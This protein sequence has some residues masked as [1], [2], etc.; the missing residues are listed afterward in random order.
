MRNA[1]SGLPRTCTVYIALYRATIP[2]PSNDSGSCGIQYHRNRPVRSLHINSEIATFFSNDTITS[3]ET[4]RSP[5]LWDTTV[6]TKVL[7][8]GKPYKALDHVIALNNFSQSVTSLEL[9]ENN[10]LEG[11]AADQSHKRGAPH[12]LLVTNTEHC[13]CTHSLGNS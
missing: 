2:S 1:P 5:L 4:C 8:S 3:S 11:L 13:A 10:R 9:D 12:I 6:R 7:S